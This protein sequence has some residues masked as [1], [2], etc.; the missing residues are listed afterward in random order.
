MEDAADWFVRHDLPFLYNSDL[1][2]H[3]WHTHIRLNLLTLAINQENVSQTCIQASLLKK[4]PQFVFLGD[5]DFCQV[6]QS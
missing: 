3:H 1:P 4:K 6:D 2:V 5:G